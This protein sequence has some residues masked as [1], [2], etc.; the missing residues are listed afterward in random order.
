MATKCY[1]HYGYTNNL[2]CFYSWPMNHNVIHCYRKWKYTSTCEPC[3]PNIV[4]TVEW[5]WKIFFSPCEFTSTLKWRFWSL[6][7]KLLLKG[8]QSGK[9][10]KQ[11]LATCLSA[12]GRN[13]SFLKVALVQVML[14]YFCTT[15]F[16]GCFDVDVYKFF[17]I[18]SLD[19]K[20]F[21]FYDGKRRFLSV[22]P[23]RSIRKEKVRK[24]G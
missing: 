17:Q 16:W 5:M 4:Y 21:I 19:W 14:S 7:T 8:F 22:Q 1:Q 3:W 11:T 6:R 2:K 20:E 13:Q 9:I 23:S 18:L 15:L 12:H 24:G 10:W